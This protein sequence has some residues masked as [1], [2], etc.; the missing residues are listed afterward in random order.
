MISHC[1]NCGKPFLIRKTVNFTPVI[2][3]NYCGWADII[4]QSTLKDKE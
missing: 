2:A 1:P 3:C 4:E